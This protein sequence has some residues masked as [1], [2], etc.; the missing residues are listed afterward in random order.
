[1]TMKKIFL[2]ILA[3]SFV[4]SSCSRSS[5]KSQ[6]E[7]CIYSQCE[8]SPLYNFLFHYTKFFPR[9]LYFDEDG[10][11][12]RDRI[13]NPYYF[14]YF[15][16]KNGANYVT[17]W[18]YTNDTWIIRDIINENPDKVFTFHHLILHQYLRSGQSRVY[19]DFII[20]ID[21]YFDNDD[22]FQPCATYFLNIEDLP[23]PEE[24]ID[25]GG[26]YAQTYRFFVEDGYFVFILQEK[27]NIDF[28][29]EWWIEWEEWTVERRRKNDEVFIKPHHFEPVRFRKNK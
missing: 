12:I 16:K 28:L 20:I 25:D 18:R 13:F 9:Y 22:L 8:K 6:S 17:V 2:I 19:F 15:F 3:I 5:D 23:E 21:Q 26:I 27:Y 7:S 24:I 29:G 1:M 4:V 14:A 10:N 11:F